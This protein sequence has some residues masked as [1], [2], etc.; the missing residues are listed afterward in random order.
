MKGP[1]V[2][3]E[4]CRHLSSS[5]KGMRVASSPW[6]VSDELW[7]LVEPLLPK[8]ER[9]SRYPGDAALEL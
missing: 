4:A 8:K 9:R 7:E 2:D 1:L 3:D 5:W 6:V